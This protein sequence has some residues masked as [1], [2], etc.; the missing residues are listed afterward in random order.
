MKPEMSNA[1]NKVSAEHVSRAA[2]LYVRQSSS[3]QVEHHLE[4]KRRQYDLSRRAV[5]L[6]WSSE[7]I[8]VVDEDQGK[9]GASAHVRPGFARM[10]TAVGRGEVGIVMSL[11]ASRLA[12]NS[13]DWANLM[14]MCRYTGTLLADEHG[15]YDATSGI[16]RMVLGVRGQ[17][18]EMELDTSIHR[19]V[20]ARWSKARRGEY[21]VHPPA[22]YDIDDLER[23][24]LA[25]D[26]SVVS[27]IRLVFTKF[28]ELQSARRVFS[29]WRQEGLK[30]PVR[31]MGLRSHPIAWLPPAYRHFLST[32][33]NPVYAG[34]YAFG[35]HKTVRELDPADP[36][37]VRV[38]RVLCKEWPVLIK[39]HHP[40][41][42]SWEKFERNQLQVSENVQMK[43]RDDANH[44]GPA[45]EGM[46]LLQGLVRCGQCGRAMIVNYGGGS[47]PA[48][49]RTLQYRCYPAHRKNG[50]KEC[51][52][53]GGR[54]VDDVVVRAFFDVAKGAG[55][56]AGA[57][58]GASVQK[59]NEETEIAWRAQI[60]RAEYEAQRAERQ[61]H[62]VEPENRLVARTLEAR[63]NA[64]LR[65]V[66]ELRAKAAA[67]R[68]QR[69][70]LTELEVARA[71]RLGADL[72]RVWQAPTTGNVDRK[73]L[74]RAVI[75]EVQ[76]RSLEKH[77]AVKIL[78]RGGA[79]TEHEVPRF[80]RGDAGASKN[81]TTDETVQLIR[82]LAV[83]LDDAQIARVLNKQG[84]RT[85]EGNPFTANRVATH[86]SRHKIACCPQKRA[87]DP[88][89]G[90]FNADEAASELGVTPG[91]IHRWLR[92][93]ILPGRQAA[94]AAPWQIILTEELRHKLKN[95]DAP[96]GF[97]G[98]TEA[99]QRLGLAK[100]HVAY[101]VKHGKLPA[102]RVTVAGRAN[103]R[104][105]VSSA[106]CGTQ[107]PLFDQINTTNPR[108]P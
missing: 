10:V 103:W 90:P 91:T 77:Y 88:R 89:Q 42:I 17:M 78:W 51:Q 7:Q 36:R 41:Y 1:G 63:W 21:L 62:A 87:R 16:D 44:R 6:G 100:P 52:L 105:D 56:E 95:G 8:V 86:R 57:L 28:D 38:R 3:Y 4:S 70:P 79:T 22:G 9:S 75:E 67:G 24:V 25:S 73:Q 32:L 106:T 11:E 20:E 15:I 108:E 93:G 54:R 97:V 18:S 14:Y 47:A 39:D 13:P 23:V 55:A 66:D 84:R 19:M 40:G 65:N 60:E 5:E 71:H 85:G 43:A 30:F 53:V 69:R 50:G 101:L 37:K 98:L 107:P 59:Q 46:G 92:D 72:E 76:L 96:A 81:A 74:L 34:A 83:E 61:F 45:R 68:T 99:A 26:E 31:R 2:Y 94:P 102:V 33:H 64:C 82:K 29:W 80:R 27:A 104:I 12:R 48:R 58:A 35:R 49:A